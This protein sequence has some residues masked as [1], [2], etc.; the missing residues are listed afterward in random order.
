MLVHQLCVCDDFVAKDNSNAMSV[1]IVD[2]ISSALSKT[3]Y[4]KPYWCIVE[5][6]KNG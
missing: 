4:N 6:E 5:E 2:D 1:A 3:K